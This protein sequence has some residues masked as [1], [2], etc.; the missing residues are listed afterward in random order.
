MLCNVQQW[1]TCHWM[2]IVSSQSGAASVACHTP[3]ANHTPGSVRYLMRAI[4]RTVACFPCHQLCPALSQSSPVFCVGWCRWGGFLKRK[5]V[6]P[7][8][9]DFQ[10]VAQVVVHCSGV[11]IPACMYAPAVATWCAIAAAAVPGHSSPGP[12]APLQ[13][14]QY[15]W[16][17]R[18]PPGAMWPL[19]SPVAS[20][21]PSYDEHVATCVP[22]S[23]IGHARKHPELPH[24]RV[25]LVHCQPQLR[26]AKAAAPSAVNLLF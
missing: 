4:S 11:H 20:M 13:I 6:I 1:H 24:S 26:T 7:L 17:M 5:A 18:G 19:I 16:K 23:S 14:S 8:S 10:A 12:C 9:L 2:M 25:H 3:P 15:P 21:H 22:L